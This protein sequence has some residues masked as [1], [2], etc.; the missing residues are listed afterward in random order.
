M[1]SVITYTS[2]PCINICIEHNSYYMSALQFQGRLRGVSEWTIEVHG[3]TRQRDKHQ[4]SHY[5]DGPE[6]V[7]GIACGRQRA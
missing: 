7:E 1:C 2:Q 6:A 3:L 4:R 5:D